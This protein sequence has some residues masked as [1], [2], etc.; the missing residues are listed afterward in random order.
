MYVVRRIPAGYVAEYTV[1]K[2]T[3]SNG[4]PIW[5]SPARSRLNV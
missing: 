5:H 2:N 3:L 1:V 4:V